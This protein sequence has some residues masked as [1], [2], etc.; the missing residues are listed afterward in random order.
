MYYEI[1]VA[2]NLH[3][4]ELEVNKR[5]KI[6][7]LKVTGGITICEEGYVQALYKEEN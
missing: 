4:L 3:E 1:A 2:S 6:Y 5:I 7:G